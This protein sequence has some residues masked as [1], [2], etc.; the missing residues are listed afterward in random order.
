MPFAEVAGGVSFFVQEF[1]DRDFIAKS[2]I[3][4]V[5]VEAGGMM[6]GHEP[7]AA[8]TAGYSRGVIAGE[9]RAFFRQAV[10]IGRYRIRVPVTA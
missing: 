8:W 5:G 3:G 1:G 10:D 6:A 9:A 4:H 2:K 7:S